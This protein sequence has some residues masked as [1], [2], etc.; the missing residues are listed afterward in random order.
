[1]TPFPF[2]K[3]YLTVHKIHKCLKNLIERKLAVNP[4]NYLKQKNHQENAEM[5]A[6]KNC[7]WKVQIPIW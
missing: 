6:K 1:M 2:F 7:K 4:A 5:H 3:T